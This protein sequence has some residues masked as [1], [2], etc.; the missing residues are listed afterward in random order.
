MTFLRYAHYTM[1]TVF[2]K[3][4]L[5]NELHKQVFQSLCTAFAYRDLDAIHRVSDTLR[6]V[7]TVDG[8]LLP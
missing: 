4:F 7:H 6:D 3:C 8:F 5:A 2:C 1:F